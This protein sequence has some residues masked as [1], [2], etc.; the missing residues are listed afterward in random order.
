M[1]GEQLGQLSQPDFRITLHQRRFS[2]INGLHLI[3][4]T[5]D[6][7][8]SFFAL[9]KYLGTTGAGFEGDANKH[10]PRRD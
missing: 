7:A 9:R 8:T 10:G 2:W 1:F 5:T 6:S 3:G 4:L